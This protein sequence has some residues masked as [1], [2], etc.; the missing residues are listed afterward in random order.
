MG[1]VIENMPTA[2]VSCVVCG[3]AYAPEVCTDSLPLAANVFRLVRCAEC[4]LVRMDPAPTE[5]ALV[6]YYDAYAEHMTS[7][8][9]AVMTEDEGKTRADADIG[10][11]ERW[12][13]P[14]TLLDIG[15]GGGHIMRAAAKRSWDAFGTEMGQR[16]VQALRSTFAADRIGR[17]DELPTGGPSRYD[18]VVLRHVLEH[19]RD[20]L[21]A[22]RRVHG[23]LAGDGV[24]L[25]EVPDVN[26]LRVRLRG[27]PLMGQMHLWHFGA[28]TLARFLTVAGFDVRE[29]C[30]RDHRGRSGSPAR[31]FVR[32]AR[33]GLEN[34]AWRVARFDIGSNLRA[35]ASPKHE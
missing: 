28:L 15:C 2:P 3:H 7:Y 5:E 8:G 32:R 9:R 10:D 4:G 29:L 26:A 17:D 23:L 11:L 20:P 34:A 6:R 19:L 35:F 14:G 27:R 1:T 18:A 33:F 30:F 31:W 22:L 13:A 12:R 25:C 21:A 16:A 24:L